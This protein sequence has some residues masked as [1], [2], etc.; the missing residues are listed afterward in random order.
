LK[1]FEQVEV[2][3]RAELRDWLVAH[4]T[5]TES[6]W[7]VTFKKAA[8]ARHLP[9]DAIVEEALSFGWVD[10]VPRALD[11]QR[12]M[13]LLSPRK[14]GSAWSRVNKAR[15]ER[16]ILSGRMAKPGLAAIDRA[17][18]DGSWHR[19]DVVESLAIPEDLAAA[20]KRH[21][22]GAAYFEGFPRSS[23][24]SILEWIGGAKRAETRLQRIEET[25]RLAA[26]NRRAHHPKA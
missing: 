2:A 5:Q 26:H 8:G 19:L 22:G 18:A 6:V 20:L 16:L 10:S 11:A 24:R 1:E 17:K 12:S 14:P 15:V 25:A 23:K 4:H 7:L 13:R 9:Y 3:S 21:E